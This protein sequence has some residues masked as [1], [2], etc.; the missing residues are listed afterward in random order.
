MKKERT[1]GTGDGAAEGSCGEQ[2]PVM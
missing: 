1:E 2:K